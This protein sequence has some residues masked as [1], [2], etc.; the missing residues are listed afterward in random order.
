MHHISA[1][2]KYQD[3]IRITEKVH[4]NKETEFTNILSGLTKRGLDNDHFLTEEEV[5]L[6][7][8]D[9]KLDDAQFEMVYDYLKKNHIGVGEPLKDSDYLDS[10]D[11]DY[12]K[13]YL[14]DI[15]SL[16][17]FSEGER[18]AASISAMAGDTDAQSRLIGMY[19]ND[20]VDIAKL[21]AGQGVLIEDLIGEG[22]V[23]L[24]IG[25]TMLGALESADEVPGMLT[26][27][28]MDAMEDHIKQVLDMRESDD[29]ILKKVNKV[30]DKARELS[31]E[32]ER[33]VTIDELVSES[34]LSRKSVEDAIRIS[35]GIEYI[36][37]V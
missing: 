16:S 10:D 6:A 26:K 25:V 13:M 7:F 32:L 33:K 22:N 8:A 15:E 27:M 37:N 36:D 1:D 5:Q 29:K 31:E 35:G 2:L 30:T 23:A 3:G 14:D 11:I 34:G 19:L 24:S 20:V 17:G 9:M 12:L 28:I 21:Y 4:M 18:Q